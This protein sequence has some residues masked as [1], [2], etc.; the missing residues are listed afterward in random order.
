MKKE[1]LDQIYHISMILTSTDR[2]QEKITIGVVDF[3][4]SSDSSL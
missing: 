1:K 3:I 2:Q 4:D